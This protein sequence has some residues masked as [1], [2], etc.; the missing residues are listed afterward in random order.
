LAGCDVPRGVEVT[1]RETPDTI[2]YFLLN[3]VDRAHDIRLPHVME[4]L[5]LAMWLLEI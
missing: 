1:T 4:E 2:Y 3:F 5:I